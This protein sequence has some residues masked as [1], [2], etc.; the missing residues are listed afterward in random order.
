METQSPNDEL[1]KP[2]RCDYIQIIAN[3]KKYV[4]ILEGNFRTLV[5]DIKDKNKKIIEQAR[6]I[7]EQ[8]R[9]I[10]EQERDIKAYMSANAA[11]KRLLADTGKTLE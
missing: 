2:K 5:K 6:V 3:L 9:D 8:E 11:L 4:K 7:K 10:K 1:L